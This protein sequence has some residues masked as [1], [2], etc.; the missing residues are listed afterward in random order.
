MKNKNLDKQLEKGKEICPGPE[1]EE[2][3][4]AVVVNV[5]ALAGLHLGV[6]VE[7]RAVEARAAVCH[8]AG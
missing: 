1:V 3:T 6:A 2:A 7:A 8:A 4:P 5:T